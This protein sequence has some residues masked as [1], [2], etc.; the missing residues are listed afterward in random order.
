LFSLKILPC[1]IACSRRCRSSPIPVD[2]VVD[3]KRV[4]GKIQGRGGEALRPP[5]PPKINLKNLK[6]L[7][8]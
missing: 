1:D 8:I 6:N 2:K 5:P 4:I 7:K 3:K